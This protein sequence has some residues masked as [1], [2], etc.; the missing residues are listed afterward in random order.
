MLELRR[1][2]NQK[3]EQLQTLRSPERVPDRRW[4]D[5]SEWLVHRLSEGVATL[6]HC[7][8]PLVI[9]LAKLRSAPHDA[10][11]GGGI[12]SKSTQANLAG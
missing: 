4:N 3:P 1:G 9:T 5:Q 8:Q 12:L 7:E 6:W 11:S 2:A 10:V